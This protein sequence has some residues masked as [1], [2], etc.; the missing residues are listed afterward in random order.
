MSVRANDNLLQ[1]HWMRISFRG[2]DA[3]T[4]HIRDTR[5]R[6][7]TPT[8]HGQIMG[9][10]DLVDQIESLSRRSSRFTKEDPVTEEATRKSDHNNRTTNVAMARAFCASMCLDSPSMRRNILDICYQYVTWKLSRQLEG[11]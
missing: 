10:G 1:E 8:N 5:G 6:K 11:P 9:S 3:T 4:S 7:S 2:G